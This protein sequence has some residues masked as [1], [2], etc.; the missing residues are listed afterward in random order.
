MTSK[1]KILAL[2]GSLR[3]H[4]FNKRVLKTAVRGAE[5]AGAEVTLIDLKDY[6]MPICNPDLIESQG[7]PPNAEKL[8]RLL[9]EHNGL[10]IAS[11]EYNASIPA[12][13][14][15][16]IDWTSRANG[17][18]KLGDCYRG[19][20]AAIMTAS[21]GNFGGIR[22]LRHLRDVLT[23]LLVHTLPVEIAVP[24]VG[25]MFDGTSDEMKDETMRETLENLGASLT[26]MIKKVHGTAERSAAE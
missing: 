8:Q 26:E 22:C 21:P 15:N 23:L 14:K 16:M 3:E 12:P 25:S 18:L 5:K 11:P 13:L 2:A 7:F 17:D 6:P 10:M 1:P 20:V 19:K 9:L 24:R 4:S